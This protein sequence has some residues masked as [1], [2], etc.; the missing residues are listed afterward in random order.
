MREGASRF[1]FSAGNGWVQTAS[2][3]DCGCYCHLRVS[4]APAIVCAQQPL[5]ALASE[6]EVRL[7]TRL[8]V[9]RHQKQGQLVPFEVSLPREVL[10]DDSTVKWHRRAH[11]LRLSLPWRAAVIGQEGLAEEDDEEK[12]EEIRTG[13]AETCFQMRAPEID[14]PA[15]HCDFA[16][17]SSCPT[18]YQ[19]R[20]LQAE[21]VS[22][23]RTT[24][25]EASDSMVKFEVPQAVMDLS[26]LQRVSCFSLYSE[27]NAHH[28][29]AS[30]SDVAVQEDAAAITG[31]WTTNAGW[32]P[33]AGHSPMLRNSFLDFSCQPLAASGRRRSQSAGAQAAADTETAAFARYVNTYH[34]RSAQVSNTARNNLAPPGWT[35][36][37][38]LP[39]SEAREFAAAAAC[40]DFEDDTLMSAAVSP[41][42]HKLEQT[43]GCAN[44]CSALPSHL[45]L[46]CDNALISEFAQNFPRTPTSPKPLDVNDLLL[47]H[48]K[49]RHQEAT[50]QPSDC[51]ALLE[52]R[53]MRRLTKKRVPQTDKRNWRRAD[54]GC[55][56]P[57]GTSA[58]HLKETGMPP[59]FVPALPEVR[60][61]AVEAKIKLED[62]GDAADTCPAK[63]S[64]SSGRLKTWQPSLRHRCV[65]A[66][67]TPSIMCC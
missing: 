25:L 50:Q 47:Q 23:H 43:S 3:E 48:C 67:Q 51:G 63:M 7:S 62:A 11:E 2:A 54:T 44:E 36:S 17:A 60:R 9:I 45:D 22:Q 20:A 30:R 31:L 5:V 41:Q 8:V 40:A 32:N 21:C 52:K 1:I 59:R 24:P 26:S 56:S 14:H 18:M 38:L 49:D 16:A 46:F 4:L 27:Y 61:A 55:S 64:A 35:P 34:F 28:V 6:I 42:S 29:P 33:A 53:R 37:I 15:P 10:P 58:S 13:V 19:E 65:A 57:K 66:M 12:P 39:G